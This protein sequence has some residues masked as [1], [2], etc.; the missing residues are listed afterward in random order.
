MSFRRRATSISLWK[1]YG[2]QV[3]EARDGTGRKEEWGKA[4]GSLFNRFNQPFIQVRAPVDS[5]EVGE[6]LSINTKLNDTIY[7]PTKMLSWAS[8]STPAWFLMSHTMD[9]ASWLKGK[10]AKTIYATGVKQHLV[11]MGIDTY[12]AL[13]ALVTYEDGTQAFFESQ[14]VSPEGAPM[15]F[16]FKFDLVGTKGSISVDTQDQM[17]HITK[18]SLKYRGTMDMRVNGRLL[19]QT[20]FTYQAFIDALEK[21]IQPSPSI[22]DG[23]ECKMLVA[24]HKSAAGKAITSTSKYRPR[25]A[26][27]EEEIAT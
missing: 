22:E 1:T 5:G 25:T 15:I 12:D 11:K 24:V 27:L 20:A 6:I 26:A 9:M 3:T 14:W 16:D 18:D 17:F 19:G 23:L 21:G 10:R 8:R 2:Y 13:Q 7:V 4:G